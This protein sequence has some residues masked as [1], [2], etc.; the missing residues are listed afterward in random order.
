MNPDAADQ[1]KR[2]AAARAAALVESGMILG[3][4][5]GT[6]AAAV[7]SRI[8]GRIRAGS[9]ADEAIVATSADVRHRYRRGKTPK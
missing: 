7:L 9:L 5:T 8:A 1:K 6:T 4:G 2:R 3:L